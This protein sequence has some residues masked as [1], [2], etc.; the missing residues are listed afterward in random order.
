MF[1]HPSTPPQLEINELDPSLVPLEEPL[2]SYDTAKESEPTAPTLNGQ[3]ELL[4]KKHE[5]VLDRLE[6]VLPESLLAE[7]LAVEGPFSTAYL[8]KQERLEEVLEKLTHVSS[9]DAP[10]IAEAANLSQAPEELPATEVEL[11]Q[12]R[13]ELILS[14]T[15]QLVVIFVQHKEAIIGEFKNKFDSLK[16]DPSASV[17]LVQ[18][19]KDV[20]Y[21]FAVVDTTLSITVDHTKHF[22][23]LY[24][25]ESAYSEADQFLYSLNDALGTQL[26]VAQEHRPSLDVSQENFLKDEFDFRQKFY[27]FERIFQAI[28]DFQDK[29]RAANFFKKVPAEV[30]PTPDSQ[31]R[32]AEDS[33]A[34]SETQS[35]VESINAILPTAAEDDA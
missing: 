30:P 31:P 10:S 28:V 25:E 4:L 12:L 8:S 22:A 26:S 7:P 17:Q 2:G 16:D 33:K 20:V 6:P 34:S 18:E 14:M 15:Y 19:L 35:V 11:K 3:S 23:Q 27:N 29:A 1:Q 5:E 32:D 21:P 13:D 24:A 9:S